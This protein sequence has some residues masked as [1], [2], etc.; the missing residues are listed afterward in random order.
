MLVTFIAF[1]AILL[2]LVLVHELG[3]FL[4]A[5]KHGVKVE[6]FGFGFPPRLGGIKK[7]E[8]LYSFNMLPLGGFVKI[9]GE[10]SAFSDDPRSFASKSIPKRASMLV[11]GVFFN[12]ILAYLLFSFVL[13]FGMPVDASDPLWE[14]R[15]GDSQITILDVMKESAAERAG[16]QIG[17][18]L[19]GLQSEEEI[20]LPETIGQIQ[21]FTRQHQGEVTGITV[22]RDE[23]QFQLSATLSGEGSEEG[24]LGIAMAD[25]G[26][27]REPWYR[28]LWSG[29]R[30]TI[31]TFTGTVKGLALL[32]GMLVS[33]E[34]VSGLVSGPVGI[35]SIVGSSMEFGMS[36]VLV[37]VATLSV[38]LALINLIPFPALD[39]GRLLFLAIEGVR[40][41]P[42]NQKVSQWAHAV[43]FSLLILLM[44]I[45]TYYD[46]KLRL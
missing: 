27:V 32:V 18:V 4:A 2:V 12:L 41:R 21:S 16:L 15:V 11:A 6:E 36:F 29:F 24:I 30:M 45:I 39:G 8:T 38:N 3:H 10:D 25:I 20:L 46:V 5:R 34:S 17:D 35:F 13:W 19:V 14:G 26:I 22:L 37:L 23:K 44:I 28:A 42:I 31:A 9:F 33:G 43:G 40:G 1:F 7:G